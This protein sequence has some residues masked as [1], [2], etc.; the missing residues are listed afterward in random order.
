MT[1]SV[2]LAQ[3]AP[4]SA[5]PTDLFTPSRAGKA[6]IDQIVVTNRAGTASNFRLSIS[7][8]NA[9]TTAKDYLYYDYSPVTSG[10][11]TYVINLG[12]TLDVGDVIRVY[13]STANLNFTVLGGNA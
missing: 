9:A 13:A 1:P 11:Y 5:T 3:L 7:L 2:I 6:R 10:A 4:S 8:K 12:I